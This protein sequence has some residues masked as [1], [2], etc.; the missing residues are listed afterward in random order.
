MSHPC[1]SRVDS[2][3]WVYPSLQVELQDRHH[4]ISKGS[5][6]NPNR[7]QLGMVSY[8]PPLPFRSFE[9]PVSSS[10]CRAC[11]FTSLG[12][13]ISRKCW[14]GR[15]TRTRRHQMQPLVYLRDSADTHPALTISLP[16]RITACPS[17]DIQRERS[18]RGG[19]K[20]AYTCGHLLDTLFTDQ[21]ASLVSTA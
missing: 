8:H 17:G 16:A 6:H 9:P 10:R 11:D 15:Y 1:R 7:Q 4:H 21:L 12:T 19:R 3:Q 18:K 2:N 5:Q 14:P 20:P 13:N